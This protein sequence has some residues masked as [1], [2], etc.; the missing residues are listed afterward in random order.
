MPTDSPA[1]R[2]ELLKTAMRELREHLG[3]TQTQLAASVGLAPNSVYRYEAGETKPD[4]ESMLA[5]WNLA[6]SKGS[7]TAVYFSDLL[8][9]RIPNIREMLDQLYRGD[10]AIDQNGSLT[11][12]RDKLRPDERVIVIALANMMAEAPD[13][14]IIKVIELLLEPWIEKAKTDLSTK[15]QKDFAKYTLSNLRRLKQKRKEEE[16]SEDNK[17]KP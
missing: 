2:A 7:H 17:K 3:L 16:A 10:V 9:E 6:L 14:R 15:V 1:A 12:E 5:L 4:L 11:S 13:A 8:I